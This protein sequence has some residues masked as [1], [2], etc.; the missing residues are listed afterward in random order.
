MLGAFGHKNWKDLTQSG[1]TCGQIKNPDCFH[2]SSLSS[3][4]WALPK[5]GYSARPNPPTP[6]M[7]GKTGT[8]PLGITRE[9]ETTLPGMDFT[10][11]SLGWL[12]QLTSCVHAGA[13]AVKRRVAW[14]AIVTDEDVVPVQ[15]VWSLSWV[16]VY[17]F[18]GSC[19]T[20]RG[21]T[22]WK[23]FGFCWGEGCGEWSP[24]AVFFKPWFNPLVIMKSGLKFTAH[25]PNSA[26]YLLL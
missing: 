9:K 25:G 17:K 20:W 4:D 12:G 1:L 21:G 16:A 18:P 15:G 22:H 6:M 3:S 24:G 13:T 23:Q 11:F 26:H 5:T 14:W 8:V 19:A 2:L 10:A 7:P